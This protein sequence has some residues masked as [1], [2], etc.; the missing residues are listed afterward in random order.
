[1]GRSST[2][3]TQLICLCCSG[4]A[5]ASGAGQVDCGCG[6]EVFFENKSL[7]K[8]FTQFDRVMTVLLGKNYK[9]KAAVH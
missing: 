4:P 6:S 7:S 8:D 2:R 1:M 3:K 5:P 9:T